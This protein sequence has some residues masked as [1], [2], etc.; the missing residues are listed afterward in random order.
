MRKPTMW[1]PNK[2]DTNP[3]VQAQKKARSWKFREL[4]YL[5]SKKT[6]ALIISFAVTSKLICAFVF[7]YAKCW[8]SH[9]VAIWPII[10][11]IGWVSFQD[12]LKAY[13]PSILN[14]SYRSLHYVS[15][16]SIYR[17]PTD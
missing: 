4:Y 11:K 2:S 10:P 12:D 7:A 15:K 16:L 14:K 3:A 13:R 17:T 8:F 1:F 9:Y 6:K 5:L